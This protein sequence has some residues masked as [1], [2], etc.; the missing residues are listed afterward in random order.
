MPP[1]QLKR[2]GRADYLA[3]LAA[4]RAFTAA[5]DADTA[6]EIW[7]CEHPPVFTLV[8]AGDPRLIHAAGA[9]PVVRNERG[10]QVT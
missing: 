9:I 1:L 10:G 5:R 8:V 4:M 7:L 2:L 3:T 6:D